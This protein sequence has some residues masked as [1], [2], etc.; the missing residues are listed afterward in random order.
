MIGRHGASEQAE[1]GIAV[2]LLHVAQHLIVGT[3]F[4]DDIHDVFK[5]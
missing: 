4:L 3:I 2:A 1:I 5:N